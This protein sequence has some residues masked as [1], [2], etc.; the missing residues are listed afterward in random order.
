MTVNTLAFLSIDYS[1]IITNKW[2]SATGSQQ[3]FKVVGG[4]L[5]LPNHVFIVRSFF[6]QRLTIRENRSSLKGGI[7]RS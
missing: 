3:G 7:K 4:H 5:R 1:M 2:G 6:M